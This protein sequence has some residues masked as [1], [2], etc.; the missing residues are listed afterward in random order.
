MAGLG[1]RAVASPVLVFILRAL[2]QFHFHCLSIETL[3]SLKSCQGCEGSH[4][5]PVDLFGEKNTFPTQR[6]P[7]HRSIASLSSLLAASSFQHPGFAPQVTPWGFGICRDH[8]QPCCVFHTSDGAN[9][10]LCSFDPCRI[11]KNI[12]CRSPQANFKSILFSHKYPAG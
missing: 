11:S 8:R 7:P 9:L 6:L 12:T 1:P 4:V 2:L 5:K 3:E 10:L